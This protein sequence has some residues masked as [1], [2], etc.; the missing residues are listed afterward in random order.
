MNVSAA[1]RTAY[2]ILHR[3]ATENSFSSYLLSSERMNDLIPADRALTT[4]LVLGAL[5]WQKRL[6]WMIENYSGRKIDQIDLE[7]RI[8]LRMAFYQVRFLTKIPAHA[9][10]NE[11]VNLA[12]QEKLFKV[13]GFINAVL[14]KG[15]GAG[16]EEKRIAQ[17]KDPI[18]RLS[19]RT[20]HPEWLIRRWV[21][22]LGE[23]ITRAAAAA[24]NNPPRIAI[25]ANRN[26]TTVEELKQ[27]LKEE[28][29]DVQESKYLPDA[30]ILAS[31]AVSNS[32][33][34]QEGHFYF[35]DEASQMIPFLLG[36]CEGWR[37][38]DLCAAPGGKTAILSQRVGPSGRV[39]AF[40][41]H[42]LR[43]SLLKYRMKELDCRN[44]AV[45]VADATRELPLARAVDAVLLDAPC[46]GL[47]TL[48]RNPEI[49]W[50]ITEADLTALSAKQ[51]EILVRAGHAVKANGLLLYSTCS[52]EPEE[53][54][55]V[56]E[57]FLAENSN[58]TLVLPDVPE[59]WR[60]F[61]NPQTKYFQT[62]PHDPNVDSF[63]AAL[64]RKK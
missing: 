51:S 44:V 25:R 63:F 60:A 1:R 16:N 53:N 20:S 54:E 38:A 45:A 39:L 28:G 52:T 17:I 21:E 61:L 46:S 18:R 34:Y 43:Q 42:W 35:Q 9:A 40:D 41:V 47:G 31:A 58:F 12:K 10:V 62:F 29:L 48:R 50:K 32:K 11:A 33:L 7:A 24:N 8:I 27:R 15:A 64:L 30:L 14:R 49:R 57:K 13:A 59:P 3:I 23:D 19:I 55:R 6:D 4:E 2:A 22:R 37:I 26:K 56:I 5:R 36:V